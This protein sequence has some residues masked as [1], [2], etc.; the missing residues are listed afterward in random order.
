MT[1]VPMSQFGDSLCA[2]SYDDNPFLSFV[3]GYV[4]LEGPFIHIISLFLISVVPY[5]RVRDPS[6][7]T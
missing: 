4:S 6:R 1:H 7:L 5:V 3:L 2:I